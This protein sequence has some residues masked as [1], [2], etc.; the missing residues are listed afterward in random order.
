LRPIV[1]QFEWCPGDQRSFRVRFSFIPWAFRV[2]LNPAPVMV[3]PA[4]RSGFHPG[5]RAAKQG[6]CDHG[7]RVSKSAQAFARGDDM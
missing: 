5:I 1:R 2:K 4:L 7:S 6:S 3:T